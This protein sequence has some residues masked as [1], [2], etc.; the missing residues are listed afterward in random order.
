LYLIN[1]YLIVIILRPIGL[2]FGG[3][4]TLERNLYL[5]KGGWFL[6]GSNLKSIKFCFKLRVINKD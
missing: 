3:F 4:K 5:N 6:I 1:K 2:L